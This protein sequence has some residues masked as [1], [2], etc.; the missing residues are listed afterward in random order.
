[1]AFSHPMRA[2][3]AVSMLAATTFVHHSFKAQ[4]DENQT[5]MLT[6]TVTKVTWTNPH[7]LVFLNVK[8]ADDAVTIWELELASPNGP[9]SQGREV[10]SLKP[11]AQVSVSGYPPAMDRTS[12][13]SA[14]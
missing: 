6:G 13:T 5:I 2:A 9:M 14:K 3:A 8:E 7:V 1:M 10:D 4:Y 11:G 12:R